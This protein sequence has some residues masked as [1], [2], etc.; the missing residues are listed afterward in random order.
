MCKG[1]IKM[2]T[3]QFPGASS[4]QPSIPS[5]EKND[6]HVDQS[7]VPTSSRNEDGD[8]DMKV[9]ASDSESFFD[10]ISNVIFFFGLLLLNGLICLVGFFLHLMVYYVVLLLTLGSFWLIIVFLPWLF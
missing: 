3:P 6:T 10:M 8:G 4:S 1:I 5:I 2:L 9:N 7:E